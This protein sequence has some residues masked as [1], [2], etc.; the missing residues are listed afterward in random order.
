MIGMATVINIKVIMSCMGVL[1]WAG[2]KRNSNAKVKNQ[3]NPSLTFRLRQSGTCQTV[4]NLPKLSLCKTVRGS[5]INWTV[6]PTN[7]PFVFA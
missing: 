4:T 3:K 2:S 6:E 5:N 7:S 1:D